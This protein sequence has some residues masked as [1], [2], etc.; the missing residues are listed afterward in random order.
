MSAT[1][2]DLEFTTFPDAIQ[3]FTT[4]QDVT[5][6]DGALIKQYQEAMENGDLEIAQKIYQQ[7]PDANAKIIN[8]IKINTIQDTAMALERFFKNDLTNY[9]SQ[10]QEEW[11]NIVNQ[12]TLIGNYNNQSSYL[13][14]NLVYYPDESSNVVYMAITDVPSGISPLNPSYWRQLTIQGEKGD[15]GDGISYVGEWQSTVSYEE[16]VLVTY[17]N[18]LYLSLQSLNIGNIPSNSLTYWQL[19][20][21]L[22]PAVYPIVPINTPPSDL[23]EGDIWFGIVE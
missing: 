21:D 9:V 22:T 10:K 15:K 3:N 5:A 7:I 18:G 11:L 4:M 12:F 19:I 14:H 1:Y 23:G 6:S 20:G 16:N 17:K 13:K 2:Q 8:S